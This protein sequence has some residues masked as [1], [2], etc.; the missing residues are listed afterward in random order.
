MTVYQGTSFTPELTATGYAVFRAGVKV[1]AGTV[2]DLAASLQRRH[3]RQG[4][5][6]RLLSPRRLPPQAGPSARPASYVRPG[7]S[8]GRRTLPG[9]PRMRDGSA[10]KRRKILY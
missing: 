1:S 2:N 7:R 10:S 5:R 6:W 3:D 9:D 8:R 4:T